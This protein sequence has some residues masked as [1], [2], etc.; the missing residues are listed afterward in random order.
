MN[1][2]LEKNIGPYLSKS[3]RT[4]HWSTEPP[5][6]GTKKIL[7]TTSEEEVTEN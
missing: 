4:N 3:E 6:L 2:L 7:K 5:A 1:I